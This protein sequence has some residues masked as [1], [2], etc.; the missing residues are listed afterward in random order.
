M[1]KKPTKTTTTKVAK[2]TIKVAAKNRLK[3]PKLRL[4]K[5]LQK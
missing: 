3:Q 5:K 2:K 4:Q 1:T